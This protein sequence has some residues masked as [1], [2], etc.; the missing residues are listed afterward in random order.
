MSIDAYLEFRQSV[1]SICAALPGAEA[2]DPTKGDLD[3]WKLG[4]KMFACH[5]ST[6]PGVSVKTRDIETARMLIEAG[7]GHKAPYFHASW[8][9]LTAD[10]AQEE[11]THRLHSSY[12]LIR[13]SLTKKFQAILAPRETN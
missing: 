6:P 11:L 7:V 13:S 1:D 2:S 5:A 3:S 8:I 10:I 9:R 12:D 4:G